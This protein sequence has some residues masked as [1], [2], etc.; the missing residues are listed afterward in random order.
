MAK[1]KR[2]N[3]QVSS[4][5]K[6]K[7][8]ATGIQT[9]PHETHDGPTTVGS[10]IPP[11]DL[12]ITLETLQSLT[13]HPNVIKSKSCK[14]LRTAVFNFRQACTTGQNA[15]TGVYRA[16]TNGTCIEEH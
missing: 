11:E 10:V 14:D 2:N 13:E 6:K 15:A 9:P 1:R 4:V 7:A 16:R 8:S 12:E 5:A 3:L